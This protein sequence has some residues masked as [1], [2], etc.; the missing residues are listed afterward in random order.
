MF[1][2]IRYM[3]KNYIYPTVESVQVNAQVHLCDASPGFNITGDV[4]SGGGSSTDPNG[5]M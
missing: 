2:E 3:K 1:K 5:G 4:I